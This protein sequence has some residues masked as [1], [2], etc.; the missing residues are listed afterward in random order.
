MGVK[1]KVKSG[2]KEFEKD[3]LSFIDNVLNII[4]ALFHKADVPAEPLPPQLLLTGAI[5]RPGMSAK[6]LASAII[7]RQSEAGA[8]V[9]NIFS[10][11]NN[12]AE[13]M[14]VIRCEELLKMLQTKSKIEVVIPPGVQVI[15]VGSNAGGPVI[16][17]GATVSIAQGYG[18]IR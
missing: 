3:N 7:S 16:S 4:E 13:S 15:T 6:Q 9:G 2:I 5:L 18:V 11:S 1:S 14:E 17:Q 10:D 8:P 12:I